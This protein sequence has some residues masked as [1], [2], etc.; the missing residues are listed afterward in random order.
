MQYLHQLILNQ[1]AT[2]GR[3]DLE[4]VGTLELNN[5]PAVV[6]RAEGLVSP[7]YNSIDFDAEKL[8]QKSFLVH[9]EDFNSEFSHALAQE[10]G[11]LIE[12]V[13]TFYQ[14][15]GVVHFQQDSES[16]LIQSGRQLSV[17]QFTPIR[18]LDKVTEVEP[19]ITA[20]PRPTR[21]FKWKK[22]AFLAVLFL[23]F[24][25]LGIFGLAA[26]KKYGLQGGER[27]K[28]NM[29]DD[30]V[31]VKPSDQIPLPN[32]PVVP[33]DTVVVPEILGEDSEEEMDI[34]E[35]ESIEEIVIPKDVIPSAKEG[36]APKPKILTPDLSTVSP[37]KLKR[38]INSTSSLIDLNKKGKD[39]AIIL[40]SFSKKSNVDNLRA[41][42]EGDGYKIFEE[43]NNN[44]TRVGIL[45]PCEEQIKGLNL[46]RTDFHPEAWIL[47][48]Q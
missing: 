21:A 10:S 6:N 48:V 1:L 44:M 45:I 32:V 36:T 40:G 16:P 29:P 47:K 8:P 34:Q 23:V 26:L 14:R 3:V 46:A 27:V 22:Y 39:C 41:M 7:P 11:Y 9:Y 19:V 43:Q 25:N 17:I 33:I 28:V 18:R 5:H 31:N 4:E 30:R 37:N 42:L 12:Q 13:G 15:G 35:L 20:M 24:F 38:H 2:L